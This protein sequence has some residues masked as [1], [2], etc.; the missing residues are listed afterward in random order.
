MIPKHAIYTLLLTKDVSQRWVTLFRA[1]QG[2][3][4][5]IVVSDVALFGNK[6]YV[7]PRRDGVFCDI[8]NS[9]LT[10]L[11]LSDPRQI[12]KVDEKVRSNA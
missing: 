12:H 9:F 6:C 10:V 2:S 11:D 7:S 4:V 3:L 5:V 8:S 1:R